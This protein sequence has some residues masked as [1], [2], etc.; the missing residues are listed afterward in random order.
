MEGMVTVSDGSQ[1][2]VSS[3]QLQ[4]LSETDVILQL[5]IHKDR[6]SKP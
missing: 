4:P 5:V 6:R 1:K 2:A 3:L